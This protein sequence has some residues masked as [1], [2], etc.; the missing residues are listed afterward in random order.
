[1]NPNKNSVSENVQIEVSAKDLQSSEFIEDVKKIGAEIKFFSGKVFLVI[2]ACA[3]I[4]LAEISNASAQEDRP[5]PLR[6]SWKRWSEILSAEKSHLRQKIDN[7]KQEVSC[8]KIAENRKEVL[9]EVKFWDVSLDDVRSV[10]IPL[11]KDESLPGVLL[12]TP[13][14]DIQGTYTEVE[15]GPE[16]NSIG[17]KQGVVRVYFWPDGSYHVEVRPDIGEPKEKRFNVPASTEEASTN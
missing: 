11:K 5:K 12:S 16:K 7:Y 15:Y 8:E 4:T 2:A 6:Y 13:N 9:W 14:G 10:Q 17:I 3:L 1:M